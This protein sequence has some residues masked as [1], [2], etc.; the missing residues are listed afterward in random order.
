M[1]PA[2]ESRKI[3]KRTDKGWT[4][5]NAGQTRMFSRMGKPASQC[6]R[7]P[8]RRFANTLPTDPA[9]TTPEIENMVPSSSQQPYLDLTGWEQVPKAYESLP[10]QMELFGNTADGS[11]MQ[12]VCSELFE[13]GRDLPGSREQDQR[14]IWDI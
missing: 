10:G 6:D 5:K 9:Q 3:L 11:C 14:I 2:S 13:T 8:A 1:S 7:L 12:P 4:A